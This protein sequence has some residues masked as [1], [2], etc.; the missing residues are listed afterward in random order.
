LWDRRVVEKIEECVGDFSI[1][2]SFRSVNDN[3]EW[4]FAGV[5]GPNVNNDRRKLWDELAR[6]ISWWDL[7]W[8]IGSDFNISR[9]PNER[10]SES[11]LSPTL[12]KFSKSIFYQGLMDIL[13]IGGSFTW[14]NHCDPPSWSK[15]DR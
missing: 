14:S 8:C 11:R 12:L 10:S 9:Y 3:F 1:V 4:A 2:C 15:I 6:L 7:P 13:L 5:Y